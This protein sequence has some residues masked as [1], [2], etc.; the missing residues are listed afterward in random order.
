MKITLSK[1]E[2]LKRFRLAGGLEPLRSDCTVE[3]T[4]GVALDQMLE[5]ALRRGYAELLAR[6]PQ[7]LLATED[8]G[9]ALTTVRAGR[10]GLGIVSL[11]DGCVR[12]F[13]IEM[14]G[15]DRPAAV[16]GPEG[17]AGMLMSL[18]NV[19]TTGTPERP[20]A[21]LGPD[22]R[23]VYVHPLTARKVA[24]ARGVLDPGPEKFTLDEAGLSE[25]FDKIKIELP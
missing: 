3:L 13:E 1:G 19:F 12:L 7:E 22:G 25:L 5:E 16:E 2:M 6:A 14:E 20:R 4:D 24:G 18:D 23:T 8:V 21:A 11:P 15:W 10:E 9:A 17:L